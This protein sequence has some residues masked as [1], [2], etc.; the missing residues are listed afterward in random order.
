MNDARSFMVAGG[1]EPSEL[2]REERHGRGA[3]GCGP[4]FGTRGLEGRALVV[5]RIRFRAG[6]DRFRILET[7][8]L[9]FKIRGSRER[10]G[11]TPTG[12]TK[13]SADERPRASGV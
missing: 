9:G 8:T 11:S 5:C 7:I 10:V 4:G 12:A 1:G 6:N 2:R 13:R 3:G